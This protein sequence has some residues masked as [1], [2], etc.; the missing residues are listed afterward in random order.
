MNL[1]ALRRKARFANVGRNQFA[2]DMSK[3]AVITAVLS[4]ASPLA[5]PKSPDGG[6][7]RPWMK[8]SLS[9]DERADLLLKRMASTRRSTWFM[10]SRR[11]TRNIRGLWEGMRLSWGFL[12]WDFPISRWLAPGSV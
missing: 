4:L 9:P 11:T 12:A 2:A 1:N 8:V 5:F 6:K 10:V 7:D 3:A